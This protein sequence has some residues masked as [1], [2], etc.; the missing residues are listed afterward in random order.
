MLQSGQIWATNVR[1]MNDVTEL[2]YGIETVREVLNDYTKAL[3]VRNP[4]LTVEFKRNCKNTI[5]PMLDDVAKKTTQFA[6]CLCRNGNLLSQW[7]GYGASGGGYAVGFVTNQLTQFCAKPRVPPAS[8]LPSA[9]VYL[10]KIIYD[11]KVQRTLI[12]SWLNAL[13]KRIAFLRAT[14]GSR[15]IDLWND[16]SGHTLLF[17]IYQ[18]LVSFKHPGFK[19]EEE[20]RFI[21]QGRIGDEDL[22]AE[23]FRSRSGKIVH[24]A[25]LSR[26]A[27][28]DPEKNDKKQL[29]GMPISTITFGPTLDAVATERTLQLLIKN[30]MPAHRKIA[31]VP[32]G[33]PFIT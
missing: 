21:Q 16:Y 33:I 18:C 25:S 1:F 26:P 9:A 30:H 19:E 13:E 6:V 31:L 10:R 4:K 3:A 22:C 15:M 11:K 5:L 27:A 8:H 28:A 32:S 2:D 7:R 17:L 23:G 29:A 14:R 20:W 12:K 24:Y